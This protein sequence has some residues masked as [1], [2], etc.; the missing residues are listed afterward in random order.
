MSVAVSDE[1]VTVDI[2]VGQIPES[3]V[4]AP[5]V[6]RLMLGV[7]CVL[8]DGLNV[9]VIIVV[10]TE[11]SEG[12]TIGVEVS[13]N[14]EEIIRVDVLIDVA[15]SDVV[16]I[17][18]VVDVSTVI[19]VGVELPLPEM[20][21][22]SSRFWLGAFPPWQAEA[23]QSFWYGVDSIQTRYVACFGLYGRNSGVS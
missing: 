6:E 19:G 8:L 4:V 5:D 9:I 21:H 18:D 10:F 14:V 22:E 15:I 16:N 12:V 2:N 11:D 3:L 13:T 23:T 20:G 1:N 7:L 17:A